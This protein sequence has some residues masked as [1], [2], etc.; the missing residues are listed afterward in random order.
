M[1]ELTRA[2]LEAVRIIAEEAG[3][4]ILKIYQLDNYKIQTKPD[5]SPLTHADLASHNIIFSKLFYA[6]QC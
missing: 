3:K 1:I 4:A 5:Y 6:S 2:K